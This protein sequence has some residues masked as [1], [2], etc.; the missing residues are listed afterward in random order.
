MIEKLRPVS[1]GAVPDV[2]FDPRSPCSGNFCLHMG[3]RAQR[4]SPPSHL[5]D[6]LR[7]Y[8]SGDQTLRLLSEVVL[9]MLKGAIPEDIRPWV[10]GASL[11]ALRKPNGSLRPGALRRLCSKVCVDLMGSSLHSILELVQVGVQTRFGWRGSCSQPPGSGPILSATTLTGC[12]SLIDLSNAFN[13]VSR[14][15]RPLGCSRIMARKEGQDDCVV[16]FLGER[17][18][19]I[20]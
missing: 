5:Q 7:C 4:A 11:V 18:A 3:C 17:V 13:C 2:D 16:W 10:C 14:G 8:S 15:G 19:S 1:P 9:L 12:L 20:Q 6:A